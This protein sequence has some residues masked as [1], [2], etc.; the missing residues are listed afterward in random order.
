[1]FFT[2]INL[3]YYKY[4]MNEGS[5]YKSLKSISVQNWNSYVIN[6]KKCLPE[7]RVTLYLS[8]KKILRRC[9][10]H[11]SQSLARLPKMYCLIYPFS[12]YISNIYIYIKPSNK[13][14][15]GTAKFWLYIKK[16]RKKKHEHYNCIYQ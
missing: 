4:A 10:L 6:S 3:K 9:S 2:K 12:R 16:N 7:S 1:M 11:S 5:S 13:W 14:I 15:K 8:L